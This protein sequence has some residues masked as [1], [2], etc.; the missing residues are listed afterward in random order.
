MMSKSAITP[1]FNGL[2]TLILPG[3]R[4]TILY[5]SVPT[6]TTLSLSVST[7][8]TEGSFKTIPLPD[9]FIRTFAVPKSI[10]ISLAT[11]VPP[12]FNH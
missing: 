3:V 4:P 2:M 7:A 6:A 5:A 8:T 1:F 9:T 12:V 11:L 10:P